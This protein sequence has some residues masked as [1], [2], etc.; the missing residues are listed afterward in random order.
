MD[1][2]VAYGDQGVDYGV[3]TAVD[4]DGSRLCDAMKGENLLPG[5]ILLFQAETEKGYKLV[6][7]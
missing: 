2:V 7:D 6:F 4:E 3:D 1:D 5:H